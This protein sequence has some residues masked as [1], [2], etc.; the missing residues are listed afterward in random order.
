MVVVSGAGGSGGW[1]TEE[2]N[3]RHAAS[4]TTGSAE[5]VTDHAAR[6]YGGARCRRFTCTVAACPSRC[7][8]VAAALPMQLPP[9]D[10]ASSRHTEARLF[11][12]RVPPDLR[13]S[14]LS[15]LLLS[16]AILCRAISFRR[17][18]DSRDFFRDFSYFPR[19]SFRE[20]FSFFLVR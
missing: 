16:C 11:V 9:S 18:E 12:R 6:S 2:C 4:D 10:E 17:S 13:P 3:Q 19:T 5:G 7:V 14:L 15:K 8:G 1:R 20:A